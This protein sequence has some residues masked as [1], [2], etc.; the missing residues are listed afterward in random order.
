MLYYN[1][2]DLKEL[3]LLKAITVKKCIVCYYSLFDFYSKFCLQW[4]SWCE[5]VVINI[6][7]I[8]VKGV[9]YC[10]ITN[11]ITKAEATLLL[12]TSVPENHE[13]M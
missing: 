8:N 13:Y 1:R 7:I 4:L 6:V 3:M 11:D 2:I 9:D 12:G 10:C 5:N